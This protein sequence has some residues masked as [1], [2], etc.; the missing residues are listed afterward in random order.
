MTQYLLIPN[1]ET[2]RDESASSISIVCRRNGLTMK[3]RW[4]NNYTYQ[5]EDTYLERLGQAILDDIHGQKR[6]EKFA[7]SERYYDK[8]SKRV[9]IF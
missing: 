7:V 6:L 2:P 8:R 1:P 4:V 5:N 9:V 3:T